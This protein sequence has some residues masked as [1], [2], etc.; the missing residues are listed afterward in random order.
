MQIGDRVMLSEYAKKVGIAR[1]HAERRGTFVGLEKGVYI[2]VRW[3]GLKSVGSGYHPD[4]IVLDPAPA[5]SNG[6]RS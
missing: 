5:V 4:F 3:D 1:R 6:E 2:K